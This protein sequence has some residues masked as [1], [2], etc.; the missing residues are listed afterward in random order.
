[1]KWK[2]FNDF[3]WFLLR[4]KNLQKNLKQRTLSWH[5]Y[6]R[7]A[8]NKI[9]PKLSWQEKQAKVICFLFSYCVVTTIAVLETANR[10]TLLQRFQKN[11]A[12]QYSVTILAQCV[13][14]LRQSSHYMHALSAQIASLL[15]SYE[16]CLIRQL[17]N[18]NIYWL[19]YWHTLLYSDYSYSCSVSQQVKYLYLFIYSLSLQNNLAKP[20]RPPSTFYYPL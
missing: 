15:Q 12:M 3:G 7:F 8:Q 6:N 2:W 16:M 5:V 13:A 17:L 4:N 10:Q 11:I 19:N 20:L 1:M 9:Q 18:F 14:P